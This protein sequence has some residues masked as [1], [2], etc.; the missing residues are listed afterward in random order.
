MDGGLV[1]DDLQRALDP[2]ISVRVTPGWTV[3]VKDHQFAF[4]SCQLEEGLQ[5]ADGLFSCLQSVLFS[6]RASCTER[7][8]LEGATINTSLIL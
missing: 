7:I 2:G 5:A 4:L 8:V 1:L 3:E 6:Q